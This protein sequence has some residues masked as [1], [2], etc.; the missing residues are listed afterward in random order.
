MQILNK[1]QMKDAKTMTFATLSVGLYSKNYEVARNA[2]SL[3]MQLEA[4]L[5]IDYEWFLKDGLDVLYF[6][7]SKH[8]EMRSSILNFLEKLS[9]EN[10]E[11]INYELFNVRKLGTQKIYEFVSNIM[12]Y[13]N[14]C[15]YE[16]QNFL[17]FKIPEFCFNEK[18]DIPL[19]CAILIDCWIKLNLSNR[20]KNKSNSNF[21]AENTLTNNIIKFLRNAVRDKSQRNLQMTAVSQMFRLMNKLGEEKDENAPTVYK[22]LVF[23]FLENY[24]DTKIREVFLYNFSSIFKADKSIPIDI[25]LDPYLRQLKGNNNANNINVINIPTNYDINDFKFLK[26]ILPHP[27]IKLYNL[28]EILEF[29]TLVSYTNLFYAKSA[30]FIIITILD[31]N[32]NSYNDLL[33]SKNLNQDIIDIYDVCISYIKNALKIFLQNTKDLMILETPYDIANLNIN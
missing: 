27:K 6:C 23:L 26:E 1:S 32:L 18:F 15:G 28:K 21:E 9:K 7:V 17:K 14:N 31:K 29:S 22:S 12:E 25:L 19:S 20:S 33:N 2:Y 11:K 24:D 5:G 30:N 16:F 13:I 4:D 8:K 10:P 3:L